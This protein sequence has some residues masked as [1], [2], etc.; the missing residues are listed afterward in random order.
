MSVEFNYFIEINA[1]KGLKGIEKY[2]DECDLPIV[3]YLSGYNRKVILRESGADDDFYW[4]MDSSDTDIMVAS[5]VFKMDRKLAWAKLESLSRVLKKA[6]FPFRIGLDGE[7]G[8][9]AHESKY[10]WK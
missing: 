2:L 10:R 4:D 7:D 6:G 9:K 3:N 1:P 5:G 8:N